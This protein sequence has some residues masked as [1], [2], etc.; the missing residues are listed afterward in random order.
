MPQRTPIPDAVTT[1]KSKS[2]SVNLGAQIVGTPSIVPIASQG[3]SIVGLK[4]DIEASITQSAAAAWK[5]SDLFGGFEL[6]KGSNTRVKLSSFKQLQ[7]LFNAL[8]SLSDTTQ[9]NKY[10]NNPQSAGAIGQSSN[11]LSVLLPLEFSTETIPVMTFDFKGVSAV[12]NCTAGNVTVTVTYLY[13][14]M[15]VQDDIINI[16][17]APTQLNAGIDID[18]S[19]YFSYA[20]VVE[21]VWF[22]VTADANLSYQ[23]FSIGKTTVYDK[24][25]AFDLRAA[26]MNATWM[27]EI[28]GFFAAQDMRTAYP[29]VGT[30]SAKPALTLNLVNATTPTFYLFSKA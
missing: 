6:K 1:E 22:D 15:A 27:Q 19:Q 16:V 12:T 2:T 24:Y 5:A 17:S 13:S 9:P 14:T 20:G 11:K 4:I 23:S 28:A 7:N 25:S 30:S 26:T 10:F 21:E 8:T 18:V 29:T 3:Q